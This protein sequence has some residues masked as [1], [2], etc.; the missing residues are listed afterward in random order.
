[1]GAVY[2]RY[3]PNG[4]LNLVASTDR[5]NN[6]LQKWQD[7]DPARGKNLDYR[8]NESAVRFRAEYDADLGRG[9]SLHAGA[10]VQHGGTTT[11]R[12]VR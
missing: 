7:N 6:S 2:A 10:G 9:F 8:S 3:T 1:M 12:S 4:V 11:G 5:L